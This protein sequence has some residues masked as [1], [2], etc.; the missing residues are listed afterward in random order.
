MEQITE[1]CSGC[2]ACEKSC[3]KDAIEMIYDKE[4]F[5]IPS[6]NNDKCIDCNICVKKCPQNNT[7]YKNEKQIIYGGVLKDKEYLQKSSSGGAFIAFAKI[8]LD[9]KGVVYGCAFNNEFKAEHIRVDSY[10]ELYKLQGSKYVQSNTG[11]TFCDVKRDIL[12]GKFV[13]YSGTPCQIAG[14]YSFLGKNLNNLF[15][16]EILCHGVPSPKLFNEYIKWREYKIGDK[17][18]GYN[19]RYKEKGYGGRYLIKFKSDKC[20]KKLP[21]MLDPYGDAFL[22]GKTFREVCYTCKYANSK[23]VSDITIGDFWGFENHYSSIETKGGVSL[24]II[25]SE[26]GKSLFE[27][28]KSNLYYIESSMEIAKKYNEGLKKP[29]KRPN[30]RKDVYDGYKEKKYFSNKLKVGIKF[31][32]RVSSLIP[33]T[34]KEKVKKIQRR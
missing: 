9:L 17:I 12:D 8:I 5:L 32:L 28:C 26:L 7:M 30:E 18:T 1:F 33:I 15:T 14:L 27:K 23:R 21:L 24:I 29:V 2:R 13:L 10:S 19:F 6:I 4:G 11:N 31:K 34:I 20:T 3:P 25:N 16:I 22:S